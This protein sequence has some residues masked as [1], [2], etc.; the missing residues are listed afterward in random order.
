MSDWQT[1]RQQLLMEVARPNDQ[2]IADLALVESL[3][4]QQRHRLWFNEADWEV[5]SLA[6]EYIYDLPDEVLYPIGGVNLVSTD[7]GDF[8][9]LENRSASWIRAHRYAHVVD[10]EIENSE[11]QSGPPCYYGFEGNTLLIHPDPA[12]ASYTFAGRSVVDYQ[13]PVA[14]FTPEKSW[15]LLDPVTNLELEPDWTNLWLINASDVIRTFAKYLM[16][17]RNY[18]DDKL[19]ASAQREWIEALNAHKQIT[20]RKRSHRVVTGHFV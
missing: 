10:G 3:R 15:K 8:K 5:D 17:T 1:V 2:E 12:D 18:R 11:I 13:V 20:I 19:A 4:T 16:A 14:T 7:S 6:N 9:P